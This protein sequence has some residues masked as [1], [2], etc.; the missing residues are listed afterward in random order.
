MK[1]PKRSTH[2]T[3]GQEP[4][5][6]NVQIENSI[7]QDLP[8]KTGQSKLENLLASEKGTVKSYCFSF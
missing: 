8:S 6:S 1:G 5:T 7:N 4:T 2:L 3:L